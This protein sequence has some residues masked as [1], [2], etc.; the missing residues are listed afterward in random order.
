[1]K[2]GVEHHIHNQDG[3]VSARNSYGK[4]P[5]RRRG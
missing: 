3:K 2:R 4:D 1:M 5:K